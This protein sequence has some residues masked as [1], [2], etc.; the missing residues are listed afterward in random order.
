MENENILKGLYIVSTGTSVT[1]RDLAETILKAVSFEGEIVV[2]ASRPDG[3]PREMFAV[4]QMKALGWLAQATLAE[5]VAVP[6]AA[7]RAM[8]MAS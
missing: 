3:T 5:R 2:D 6:R 4:L 7:C 1:I 8:P